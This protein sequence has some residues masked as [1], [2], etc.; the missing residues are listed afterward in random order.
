MNKTARLFNCHRCTKQVVI[1]SRCDRGNSY[2]AKSCA[3]QSRLENHR[4]SNQLYQSTPRGKQLHAL[5]QRRYR[6]RQTEKVTDR[7]SNEIPP[8]DLLPK[9]KNERNPESKAGVHCDFCHAPVS[10]FLRNDYLGRVY[11]AQ[12]P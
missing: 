10:E 2:C 11:C 1:C 4:R 3:T 9:P 6:Q 8:N 5:R 7:G 12:A